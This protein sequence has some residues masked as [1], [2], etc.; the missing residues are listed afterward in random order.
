MLGR[1]HNLTE[2]GGAGSHAQYLWWFVAI[3]MCLYIAALNG[4]PLYYYD[5]G[6][7]LDNGSKAL[8][9]LGLWTTPTS[10][11]ATHSVQTA[12]GDGTVN[13][14]RSLLYSLISAGFALF[15]GASAVPFAHLGLILATVWLVARILVR[16]LPNMPMVGTVVGMCFLAAGLGALPFYVAYLMPDIF[17]GILIL[18]AAIMIAIPGRLT[19]FEALAMLA[20][21]LGAVLSHPSHLLLVAGLV[22]VALLV[23]LLVRQNYWWRPV[24]MLAAMAGGGVAERAAFTAVADKA[25]DAEVF[26]YPF[27]TA[28]LIQDGVGYAQLNATCPNEEKPTC[29]LHQ[30]L[31]L[32]DDPM[33]LTAS[34]IIFET[35][36]HLAS[37]RLLPAADQKMV[38]DAQVAFAV[39]TLLDRPM[40]VIGAVVGNTLSQLRMFSIEMTIPEEDV[41]IGLQQIPNLPAGLVQQ[42][43][44]KRSDGAWIARVDRAH[45]I[46]YLLSLILVVGLALWPGLL[47]KELRLLVVV[48]ALGLLGNAFICGAVS[49]PA[50]RYGAR[51][52]WLVPFVAALLVSYVLGQR[53][54]SKSKEL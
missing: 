51:V 20:L 12:A 50:N 32:S 38:A 31:S 35:A 42:G 19:V 46:Y 3:V 29:K 25:L 23:G 16:E 27:L 4:G 21:G 36:P 33:R 22:L 47:P 28:R 2:P 37:F 43:G 40:G 44:L 1:Q 13:G 6:G 53:A 18:L 26:Y 9:E 8:Q 52:I 48:V 14:S 11:Q 34:H 30:A 24:L 54:A 17:A 15:V 10:E 39:E 7:Y 41:I 5:S 45:E 49:Q